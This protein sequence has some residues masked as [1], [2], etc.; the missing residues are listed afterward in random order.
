MGA[1]QGIIMAD[2][3]MVNIPHTT[4]DRKEVVLSLKEY[5]S[6]KKW[7]TL[8]AVHIDS[9]LDYMGTAEECGT[10]FAKWVTN[11]LK[12]MEENNA[13]EIRITARWFSKD[14]DQ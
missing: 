1:N 5:D 12:V 13:K 6:E 2:D 10:M 8:R 11:S 14:K 3:V 4:F 7:F 9:P